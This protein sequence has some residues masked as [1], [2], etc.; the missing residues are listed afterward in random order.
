VAA[1]LDDA[2]NKNAVSV[3]ISLAQKMITMT[4][5]MPD[6]PTTWPNRKNM[7]TP[8]MVIDACR[9]VFSA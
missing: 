3:V 1:P 2:D 5:R 9:A 7:M 4:C 8:S 6:W